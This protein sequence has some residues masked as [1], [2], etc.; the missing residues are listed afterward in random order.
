MKRIKEIKKAS[1][2]AIIG[3]LILAALKISLGLVSGSLAVVGDGI[4]STTDIVTSFITLYTARI[5]S[6]KPDIKYPY[7]YG[8]AETIAAKVLSFV[9]FFVG[10]Q[11]FYSTLMRLINGSSAQMP[12]VLA[13]YVTLISIGGKIFLTY[14]QFKTGK[15]TKSPML[16]ANARNMR[17]DIMISVT[18]LTGLIFTN[19]LNL[20][21]LDL[22]TALAV[23]IWIIKT[24][25]EI[26]METNMELMD[27]IK[28]HSIYNNIFKAV[29]SVKGASN[30]HRTRVRRMANMYI[31][32][33]DIEVDKTLKV[34]EAHT[35]AQ[36][37]E[38][39]IKKNIE[40]VYDVIVHIEPL[41]NVE[42]KEKYG[43]S[44]NEVNQEVIK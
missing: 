27:G 37:V 23:S 1:W 7:G 16:I 8:R 26:F 22:L 44:R 43:L 36:K 28:D 30:P 34:S 17:N 24:A 25:F 10:A 19:L 14:F 6:K 32:D 40:N 5:I 41:G 39:S 38:S 15:I 18:V 20:P 3:N 42:I 11:F 31:I 12:S 9:I 21:L 13:I 33:L 4:D 29:E 35:I 2:I